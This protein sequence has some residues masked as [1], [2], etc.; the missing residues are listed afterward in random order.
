MLVRESNRYAKR[1]IDLAAE[2]QAIAAA[3]RAAGGYRLSKQERRDIG[4]ASRLKA[5]KP[6]TAE[7]MKRFIGLLIVMGIVDKP[8]I[9]EY[10]STDL[11]DATPNFSQT[12]SRNRFQLLMH[13]LHCADNTDRTGGDML[14]KVRPLLNYFHDIMISLYYPGKRLS[15]D[16]SM[17]PFRGR[18]PNRQYL[19]DKTHQWGEKFYTLSDAVN[20]LIFRVMLYGGK[21]DPLAGKGHA[22]KVVKELAADLLNNGHSLF[23]DNFYNSAALAEHLL[24][25]GTYVTGTMK[26]QTMPCKEVKDKVMTMKQKGDI[27][28]R[29][30]NNGEIEVS[31]WFDKKPVMMIS[32]EHP[33]VISIVKNRYGVAKLKPQCIEFYNDSMGGV[34]AGDQMLSYYSAMRKNYSWAKKVIIHL[35]DI[36]LHNA[37]VLYKENVPETADKVKSSKNFR[38][39]VAR[40]YTHT[41][42]MRKTTPPPVRQP[43]ALQQAG[44]AGELDRSPVQ[45]AVVY[46]TNHTPTKIGRRTRRGRESA[47]LQRICV[48]CRSRNP[49]SQKRTVYQCAKCPKTPALCHTSCFAKYHYAKRM[50]GAN[51]TEEEALSS[52]QFME[53]N[54]D[55]QM[56]EEEIDTEE[57]DIPFRHHEEEEQSQASVSREL[58]TLMLRRSRVEA[59]VKAEPADEYTYPI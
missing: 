20:A 37:Y 54:S 24:A 3:N 44:A 51:Q 41:P 16:E 10:W 6:T 25:N 2:L 56:G 18:S 48:Y 22:G 13:C 34:D 30:T 42:D 55:V 29:V 17:M 11:L 28:R 50:A 32:T 1:A 15:I 57:I 36:M 49:K 4:K 53:D 39:Y 45:Q 46:M 52:V 8:T 26:K 19:P 40:A 43:P 9:H 35:V 33:A 58:P 27:I 59:E 5:W 31:K 12:M 21:A 47:A 38:K 7:E 14:Y 23:M